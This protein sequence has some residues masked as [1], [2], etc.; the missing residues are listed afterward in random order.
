MADGA[1]DRNGALACLADENIEQIKINSP[2]HKCWGMVSITPIKVNDAIL[3]GIYWERGRQHL[4]HLA[5]GGETVNMMWQLV[6]FI[7]LW[8]DDGEDGRDAE[9]SIRLNGMLR[10]DSKSAPLHNDVV[11]GKSS[12]T[13]PQ[14][15]RQRYDSLLNVNHKGLIVLKASSVCSLS[16]YVSWRLSAGHKY[17]CVY[18][19]IL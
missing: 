5:F 10:R 19:H 9:G 1:W 17:L 16:G 15:C 6:A 8:A 11:Y 7:G 12:L 13:Q 4:W 2:L 3:N 14:T 18:V